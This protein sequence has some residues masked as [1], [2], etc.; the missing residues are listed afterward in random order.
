MDAEP[1]QAADA[2]PDTLIELPSPDG[3]P[4]L[5]EALDA[6][7]TASEPLLN[8]PGCPSPPSRRR[9]GGARR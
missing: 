3:G 1:P 2:G 6:A 5:P 9:P 7:D 4:D 8:R